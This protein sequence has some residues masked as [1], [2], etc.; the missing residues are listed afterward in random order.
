MQ[1]IM[2]RSL[3]LISVLVVS[4]TTVAFSQT[5]APENPEKPAV[6]PTQKPREVVREGTMTIKKMGAI[7]AL[8][9][10]K[11]KS[12]RSGFWQ[13]T[14]EKNTVIVVTDPKANRMRIMVPIRPAE[15]LKLEEFER[16]TQANFD[17]ALDSRY[18][19]AQ[20]LLW[21]VYIHPLSELYPRQFI[22]G[23]GQTVNLALSYGKTYNSGLLTYGG[24]DSRGILRRQLID[25][26]LKQG[27]PI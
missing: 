15:G 6:P 5:D 3:M 23:I 22:K 16:I 25:R 19:I 26:L 18:A 17:T 14:I 20:K 1:T 9:D 21:S 8:L 7:I 2:G 10:K 24:G 27:I 11:A 13:F 12:L 4:L